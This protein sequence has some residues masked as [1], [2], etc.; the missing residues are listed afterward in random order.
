ML[1]SEQIWDVRINKEVVEIK[2]NED[3][4]SDMGIDPHKRMLLATR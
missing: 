3:F 1:F 4:I 2:E